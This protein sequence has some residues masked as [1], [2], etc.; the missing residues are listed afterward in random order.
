M[1]RLLLTVCLFGFGTVAAGAQSPRL[2]VVSIEQGLS[3]GFIWGSCQD[4]DG[5]LWFCTKNGLNRYD[6][7]EFVAFKNDA[8]DPHSLSDNQVLDV[9]DAGEFLCVMAQDQINLFHKRT[10]RFFRLP[11]EADIPFRYLGGGCLAENDHT[12]WLYVILADGKRC[13][14]LTWPPE[15]PDQLLR[16]TAAIAR[17]RARRMFSDLED[18][19]LAPI[20]PVCPGS[21]VTLTLNGFVQAQSF[22]TQ[23]PISAVAYGPRSTYAADLDG[24]IDVLSASSFDD[25]IVWYKNDGNG[26]F[27]AQTPISTSADYASSVCVA[28]LDDDGDLDVLS[29]SYFDYKISWYKNRTPFGVNAEDIFAMYAINGGTPQTAGSTVNMGMATFNIP[30]PDAGTLIVTKLTTADGCQAVTNQEAPITLLSAPGITCPNPVLVV[31]ASQ[32]PAVNLASVT[33]SD[34]CG[35]ATKTHD[36]DAT[37]NQTCANRRT[38]TRTYRAT[39]RVGNSSTCAQV[40]T[41]FDDVKPNFTSVPANVLAQCNS[42][43]AVGTATAT[44]GCGGAVTVVYNGQSVTN[45]LCADKYTLVCQWTATDACGNTKTATQ[46]ITVTRTWE[47]EDLCGNT[48]SVADRVG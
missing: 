22:E 14:R 26:G 8:Y 28:D 7:Y 23:P 30:A 19:S 43:P 46:S 12:V 35:G 16:D 47:A 31:C 40:I 11:R 17:V 25:Q 15:M 21:D 18:I 5:F 24:D 3:Q 41:V 34:N 32:I 42:I 9:C 13:Y 20:T 27:T 6:G 38:V 29:A 1:Y 39:D 10:H 48:A 37:T 33:A 2:E 36:G 44:D 45:V 4:R